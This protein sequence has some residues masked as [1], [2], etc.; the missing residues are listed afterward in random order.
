MK[1]ILFT[2][3]LSF[4]AAA[5]GIKAQYVSVD[6]ARQTALQFIQSNHLKKSSV[7]ND[8]L[9]L[10]YE[11]KAPVQTKSTGNSL[12]YVFNL[13]STDGF[14]I[15]S[16]DE[17]TATSII[18]YSFSNSF[19]AENMPENLKEWLDSYG[20][21]ISYL[22]TT[23][24]DVKKTESVKPRIS[25]SESHSV[26]F[27]Q[28][29][30][31]L[32]DTI[33]VYKDD[34]DISKQIA[35]NSPQLRTFPESVSPMVST[36]WTQNKPFNNYLPLYGSDRCITGCTATAMGQIMN[37][38]RWPDRGQGSKSYNSTAWWALNA[39]SLSST[40]SWWPRASSPW[41]PLSGP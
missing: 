11:A 14:V 33:L 15:V 32:E 8:E 29:L 17:R 26:L 36:T 23:A 18:G 27:P 19:Q 40:P 12:L 35:F 6:Q 9:S 24:P 30:G 28:I 31:S 10:V 38:H 5:S 34:S 22:R 1:R 39:A 2:L 13:N 7:L 20:K 21:Q 3:I 4:L 25:R 37:Y 41:R 16:G